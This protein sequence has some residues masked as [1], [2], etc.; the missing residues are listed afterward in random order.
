VSTEQFQLLLE[1]NNNVARRPGRGRPRDNTNNINKQKANGNI[2]AGNEDRRSDN[3]G[4][5]DGI[6]PILKLMTK[7]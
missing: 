6:S 4:W 2:P 1:K 3:D 7:C 5:M